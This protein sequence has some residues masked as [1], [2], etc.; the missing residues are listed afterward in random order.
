MT[1]RMVAM[2]DPGARRRRAVAARRPGVE[3]RA[4]ALL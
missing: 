1:I 4:P 2:R 3:W